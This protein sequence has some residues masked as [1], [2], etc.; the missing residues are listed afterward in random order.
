MLSVKM[1]FMKVLSFIQGVHNLCRER[2]CNW[3][4]FD[5][6]PLLLTSNA[7][8]DVLKDKMCILVLFVEMS[9]LNMSLKGAC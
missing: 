2:K 4:L 8:M 1:F 6:K 3:F 9:F 7:V 5:M